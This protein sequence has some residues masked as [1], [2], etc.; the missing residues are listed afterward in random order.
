MIS[1]DQ[2]FGRSATPTGFFS[3][4]WDG[5]TSTGLQPNG[6]Y[7][8]RVSVLKALRDPAN[9]AHWEIWT[10]PTATTARP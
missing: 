3:F 1:E 2:Y 10:T 7:K 8:V 9:P 6:T 5:T 4:N